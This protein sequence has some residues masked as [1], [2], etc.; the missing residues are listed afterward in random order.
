MWSATSRYFHLPPHYEDYLMTVYVS[1]DKANLNVINISALDFNIWQCFS[2][3]WTAIHLG[4]L[5]ELPE[6]PVAQLYKHMTDQDGPITLFKIDRD[7]KEES[8]FMW[9]L[10]AHPGT[11]I[12]TYSMVFI[13][14][15]EVY[16]FKRFWCR[17]ATQRC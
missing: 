11:Y 3:N 4:K 7:T 12:Q 8:S 1:L 6:I 14:C 15:I 16:C 9:K 10:L 13:A 2:S 5:V 17:P